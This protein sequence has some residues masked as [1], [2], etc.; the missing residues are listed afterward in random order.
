MKRIAL[1]F[2]LSLIGT[3]PAQAAA[4]ES[5]VGKPAHVL[6]KT[7]P[8]FAKAYRAAA[9]DV[10]LPTWT[11]RLSAGHSAQLVD[12]DGTQYVLTSAC[13]KNG[14][15]DERLYILFDPAAKTAS[16]F[17]FLPPA[18]DDASDSRTAFSQWLG[19]P[20]KTIADFLLERAVTDARD[21]NKPNH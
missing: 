4:P 12:I 21:L 9:L 13:S 18:S 1:V 14:C 3:L 8:D 19:K 6:L 15:L 11:K 7:A 16:G 20:N 2:A 17:F 10:E 5:Y